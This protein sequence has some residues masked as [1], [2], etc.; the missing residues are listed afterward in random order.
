MLGDRWNHLVLRDL[1]YGNRYIN[2]ISRGVPL[3]FRPFYAQRLKELEKLGIVFS[4]VKETGQGH[5]YVLTPA[6]EALVLRLIERQ[7]LL[8]YQLLFQSAFSSCL[9]TLRNPD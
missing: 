6:G 8:R 2:D 1:L 3:M 4:H 9:V 5:E 7:Y